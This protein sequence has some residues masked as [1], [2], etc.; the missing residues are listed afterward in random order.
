MKLRIGFCRISGR[1]PRLSSHFAGEQQ[2]LT[3]GAFDEICGLV[4]DPPATNISC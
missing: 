4:S 1:N 2:T 3:I